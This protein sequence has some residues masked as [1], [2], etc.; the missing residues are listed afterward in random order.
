MLSYFTN[1]E[2]RA[3]ERKWSARLHSK[4]QEL[5]FKPKSVGLQSPHVFSKEEIGSSPF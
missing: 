4:E 3:Q 5:G 1:G 2:L